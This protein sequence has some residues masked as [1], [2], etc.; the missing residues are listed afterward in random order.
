RREDS[1]ASLGASM[2]R[3][4]PINRSCK[5]RTARWR[6]I[7]ARNC[8]WPGGAHMEAILKQLEMQ[9]FDPHPTVRIPCYKTCHLGG[10]FFARTPPFLS[11]GLNEQACDLGRGIGSAC[12]RLR[13][14]FPE[15]RGSRV[16]PRLGVGLC[17]ASLRLVRL[18]L[19]PALLSA[20][21]LLRLSLRLLSLLARALLARLVLGTRAA[22][23][24]NRF[25][26]GHSR[27]REWPLALFQLNFQ[28]I[29]NRTNQL[30]YDIGTDRAQ[31]AF[32]SH[33]WPLLNSMPATSA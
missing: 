4:R 33:T 5:Q 17:R 7:K 1:S 9:L 22:E 18:P 10:A 27:A 30:R 29:N 13:H 12:A 15:W 31:I 28:E 20:L 16:A 23:A 25:K 26:K 32:R 24:P 6:Q 3:D 2:R 8:L 11:G 19:L 14:A 21:C